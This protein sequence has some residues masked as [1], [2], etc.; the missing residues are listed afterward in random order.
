MEVLKTGFIL[1]TIKE[2]V[3]F[4]ERLL[5]LHV[6]YRNEMLICY[7]FYGSYLKLEIDD[8]TEQTKPSIPSR[9]GT[10]IRLT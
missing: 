1:Y 8:E 6:L 10:C 3:F 7:D 9:D 2:C 5:G 4:Y